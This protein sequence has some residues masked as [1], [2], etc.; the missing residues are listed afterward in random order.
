MKRERSLIMEIEKGTVYF[1]T[2]LSGA[3]KTT[4]GNLLFEYMKSKKSNVI[5]IDGDAFRQ[6]MRNEDYSEEGRKRQSE[7]VCRMAKFLIDQGIDVIMCAI[8][9]REYI[10]KQNREMLENYYEIFL[11][12]SMDELIRRDSKGLYVAAKK[13]EIKNVYGIDLIPEFPVKPDLQIKNKGSI[14]PSDACRLIVEY[15]HL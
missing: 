10:R 11:D 8:G 4:V 3:G 12:V 5:I 15:F 13:G 9:M 6:V 1:I 2:G 7:I 14:S